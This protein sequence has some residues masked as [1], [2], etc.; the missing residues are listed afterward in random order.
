MS[1]VPCYFSMP[2]IH[3]DSWLPKQIGVTWCNNM[4]LLAK[5]WRSRHLKPV[6]LGY[7]HLIHQGP[8]TEVGSK[9]EVQQKGFLTNKNRLQL[10]YRRNLTHLSKRLRNAAQA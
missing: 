5:P 4:P 6:Q 3:S 2:R 10:K 9:S 8:P 7:T 1:L